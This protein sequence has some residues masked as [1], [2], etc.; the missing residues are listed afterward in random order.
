MI[1]TALDPVRT[2]YDAFAGFYDA[3]TAEHRD[4][5]WAAALEGVARGAGLDGHRLLDLG[6]GTG[7]SFLPMLDRGY[8]VVGV[9][10]SPR[11]L[12]VAA[13]KAGDRA[14]LVEAD[15]RR[16][17]E[18]GTFD[19]VW[20]LGD[21]LNYLPSAE[22]LADALAAAAGCLAAGG[23]LLFDVNALG[24]FRRVYS[25]LLAR[26]AED[27]VL[28]LDGHGDPELAPGGSAEVWI[29]RLAR[30]ADGTWSRLRT[31]HRHRHHPRGEVERSLARAGLELVAVHGSR[32]DGALDPALDEATHVKAVYV[33][34]HSRA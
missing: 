34:R 19:L 32:P 26:P 1:L 7:R 21:A 33:A 5:E 31:V 25:S 29:D 28:L 6:C 12:D 23:V 13:G 15:V 20:S 30:S 22:A 9:D 10:V 18:L 14:R 4:A 27:E 17:P 2:A 24:T 8:D 16:L 11:M 3:F